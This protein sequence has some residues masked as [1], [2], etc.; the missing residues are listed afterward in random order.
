M[1]RREFITLFGGAAAAW[2]L[3]AHAQQGERMRR[4]GVL[5]A[6][7]NDAEG[8]SRLTAFRQGLQKLGWMDGRVQIEER[9]AR[10]EPS[11]IRAYATELVSL[12]PDVILANGN[13]ALKELHGQTR[14]IPI[15]FVALTDP[16]GQGFV[17]SL[18]RPGGNI[19]GFSMFEFSLMGKLLETL[20]QIAPSIARVAVIF[21]PD[22]VSAPGHFRS[23]EAAAPS[24]AVAPIM[25]SARDA[26]EITHA[27]NAVARE[28]NGAL[29]LPPDVTTIVHRELITELAMRHR[30]P[31]IYAYRTYVVSGGLMSYG[32]DVPDLYRRSA[33][34][35]DRVL[36]G[37]KPGELPV[38]APTKFE[39]V[40]NLKT[41]K[42]LGLEVPP[43][44]L[45][46]A[47][48][49]IE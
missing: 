17:E 26:A 38:Q 1:K 27:I 4:I 13:R 32:A 6:V 23:L 45:A 44:L 5:M 18:A 2:P 47:D 46:R 22:N 24:F 3:K 34:Y 21:H 39:L 49:V 41:A 33:S 8:Q 15:V 14:S 30:L 43:M 29:L 31:A 25:A 42:A 10:A 11:R 16:V 20:K 36:R 9:W 37:E 28:P 7:A 35:V 48:E 12:G 40:I 19:T